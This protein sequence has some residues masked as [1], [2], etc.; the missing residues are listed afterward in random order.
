[1]GIISQVRGSL[2]N[3][4]ADGVHWQV[5]QDFWD[6]FEAEALQVQMVSAKPTPIPYTPSSQRTMAGISVAVDTRMEA[7]TAALLNRDGSVLK[8][9]RIGKS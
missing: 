4:G 8:V 5:S 6:R 7:G 3:V 9:I 2:M 1:M